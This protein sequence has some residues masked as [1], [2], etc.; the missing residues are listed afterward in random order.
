VSTDNGIVCCADNHGD[1]HWPESSLMNRR[2][3]FTVDTPGYSAPN[4][5]IIVVHGRHAELKVSHSSS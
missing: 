1:V 3:R 5:K 4:G 2:V